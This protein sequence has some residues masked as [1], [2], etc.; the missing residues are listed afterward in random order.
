[1]TLQE[2]LNTPE[3][4]KM[5]R[6]LAMKHHPDRGGKAS[7]MKKINA[8]KIIGDDAIKRIYGELKGGRKEKS[9]DDTKKEPISF[10][11]QEVMEKTLDIIKDAFRRNID[12]NANFFGIIRKYSVSNRMDLS[13][14]YTILGEI[15]TFF[16]PIINQYRT[17]LSFADA[18]NNA[19]NKQD[20]W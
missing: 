14:T 17:K 2:M 20:P 4:K 8:A 15:G 18:I 6:E 7:I 16:V 13:V 19:F 11:Y 12:K 1:M 5:Y 10:N 9:Y 3:A